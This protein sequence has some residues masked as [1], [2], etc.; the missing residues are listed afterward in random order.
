[1]KSRLQTLWNE[2]V[3][4]S[5]PCPQPD[6]KRVQRRVD[7]ALD[8]KLRTFYPRRALR[9]ALVCAA[10]LALLTGTAVAAAELVLPEHNVLSAFFRGENAPGSESL[11]DAQP[12]SV[13]DDNYT[14]TLTSSVA[15]KSRLFFTLAIESK[16]QEALERL[17]SSAWADLMSYQILG[18]YGWSS[19]GEWDAETNILYMDVIASWKWVR[20]AAIRLNL[21][22]EDVWLKFTI[23]PV[24]DVKLKI[25]AEGQGR[26]RWSH[27]AKG[28]VTLKRVTLSPLA[29]QAEY[30]TGDADLFP[31]LYF[32]WEDGSRSAL[33]PLLRG[34]GSG[35]SRGNDDGSWQF[36]KSYDFLAV[37]DISQVE[38]LVFEDMAYPLDG[39][40]P[41]EVDISALP[42]RETGP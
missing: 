27:A 35:S 17:T 15:D 11:V 33:E 39:G 26:S 42:Q 22:E 2:V 24:S 25:G 19:D 16:N 18:S 41:Y 9:L 21:M 23:K 37:Q 12:V 5:G 7:A 31:V 30:T 6:V 38:A 34:S 28:P 1:V 14:M 40:E 13:S 29:I 8:G 36:A 20:H 4:D 10:A 3:P 32:L